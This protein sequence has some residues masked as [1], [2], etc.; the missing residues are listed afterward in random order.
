MVIE[1][2]FD[3]NN[4]PGGL[5]SAL[6]DNSKSCTMAMPLRLV[7]KIFEAAMLSK[8]RVAMCWG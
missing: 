8:T 3:G 6:L 7:S 2:H 4:L 5:V 1:A